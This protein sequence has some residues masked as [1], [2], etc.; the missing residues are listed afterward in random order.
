MNP[1]TFLMSRLRLE[2]RMLHDRIEA[3]SFHR[4]LAA[5]ALGREEYVALLEALD[6]VHQG[7]E[8]LRRTARDPVTT[9]TAD[10]LSLTAPLKEDLADARVLQVAPIS[11]EPAAAAA[12]YIERLRQGVATE[13]LELIGHL[14][15]TH[16]SLLGGLQL[17]PLFLTALQWPPEQMRYFGGLGPALP[18]AWRSFRQTM[19]D[20]PFDRDT[21]DRIVLA[22]CDAFREMTSIYEA[23]P[24]PVATYHAEVG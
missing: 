23:F 19:A 22:A 15:V 8:S 7:L 20:H 6:V 4:R 9:L 3:V 14:Y 2:T 18:Q 10:L 16:G 17:R 24:E 12:E 1:S 21:Q 5:G 11:P 13:P